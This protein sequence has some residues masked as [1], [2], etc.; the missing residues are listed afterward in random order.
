MTFTR[1]KDW[2]HPSR[3]TWTIQYSSRK[4]EHGNGDD[5]D[6]RHSFRARLHNDTDTVCTLVHLGLPKERELA[7]LTEAVFAI[8]MTAAVLWLAFAFAGVVAAIHPGT[9]DIGKGIVIALI[10]PLWLAVQFIRI[11]ARRDTWTSDQ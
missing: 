9:D 11:V 3:R 6:A 7:G 10:W 2:C 1:G 8:L 5:L 4:S